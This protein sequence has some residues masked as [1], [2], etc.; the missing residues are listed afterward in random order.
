MRAG[1]IIVGII[2]IGLGIWVTVGNGSYSKTDTLAQ[3]GSAK[4]T[5]THD[6]ALPQWVGIAGIVIGGLVAVAGIAR[7]R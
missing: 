6:K 1:L 3:V 7:K 4:I 2:L 5:A